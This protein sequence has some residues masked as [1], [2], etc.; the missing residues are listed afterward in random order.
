[1][2]FG[3]AVA[4]LLLE[5]GMVEGHRGVL[6][7]ATFVPMALVLLT[8]AGHR[9]EPMYQWFLGRV[10][11]RLG[12]TPF[13][14]TL[15]ASAAFYGYAALRRAPAAL[16]ALTAALLALAFVSRSTLDLDSLVS[17]REWPILA[18]A[19]VQTGVGLV[20]RSAW[21]CLVGTFCAV[22]SV[23]VATR[24]SGV[25]AHQEAL[26]FHLALAAV[27]LVGAAFEDQLGRLLRSV[28]ATLA[29]SGALV[30]MSGRFGH[31]DAA[32]RWL[33]EIYPMA[34]ALIIAGYG[35]ILKHRYS[36]MSAMLIVLFW[37]AAMGCRG[38]ISLRRAVTGLDYIAFGVIFFGL[39]ILTSMAKGGVL[40]WGWGPGRGRGERGKASK[41]PS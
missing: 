38:Y 37:A 17:P 18:A 15:L 16:D 28:A 8:V 39:A 5:I 9:G 29:L 40:R 27:L 21:R 32:P 30:A 13:F 25:L 20:R 24:T 14:V 23:T 22:A 7:V 11:E 34:M 33:L 2:P 19:V 3:L 41:A 4:V 26:V 1:V 12:G 36:I 35:I 6:R 31:T 10:V